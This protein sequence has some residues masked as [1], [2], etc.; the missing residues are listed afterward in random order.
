MRHDPFPTRTEFNALRAELAALR[1]VVADLQRRATPAPMIHLT[2][3]ETQLPCA[4]VD[5]RAGRQIIETIVAA[6]M[7]STGL[8]RAQLITSK[9]RFVAHIRQGVFLAAHEKGASLPIIGR[10]FGLHHT[11][12]LH[13]C[14]REAVRRAESQPQVAGITSAE[15]GAQHE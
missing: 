8:T 4:V 7:H 15:I 13:G 9:T 6:A 3:Q 10:F 11:T 5:Q 2:P 12:V 14:E 1:S